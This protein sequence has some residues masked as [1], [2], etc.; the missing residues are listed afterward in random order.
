MKEHGYTAL[1][2]CYDALMRGHDYPAAARFFDTVIKKYGIENS[3]SLLELG[4]GTGS[5]TKELCALGYDMTALD[6]SPEMLSFASSKI[7]DNKVLFLCQDMTDFEFYG[8]V[9]AIVCYLDGINYILSESGLK[10]LF[11]LVHNYLEPGGV[12]VFDVNTEYKFRSVF[13]D[14]DFFLD[15]GNVLCGWRNSFDPE[16]G[17][18][19]FDLTIFSRG[20][21]R[22]YSRTDE[23]QTE[24]MYTDK[25]LKKLI[26]K[27][28]LTLADTCCDLDFSPCTEKSERCFYICKKP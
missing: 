19:N 9:G 20:S 25:I 10:K 17:L 13:A 16:S 2:P 4:C 14:R 18:C 6:L 28:G 5:L 23:I 21:D 15:E 1:A 12:F 11:S 26:I 7:T 8:S 24:R 27:S 22:R 3:V